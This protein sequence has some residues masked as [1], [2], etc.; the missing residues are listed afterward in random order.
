MKHL[1]AIVALSCFTAGCSRGPALN[2]AGSSFVHPVMMKWVAEY[3]TETGT[4]INYQPIG[5]GGGIGR[6]LAGEVDFACTDGP[7]TD[8][9]L[10]TAKERGGRI[11]HVP[12]VLGA[13]V[14]AYNL[15]GVKKPLR[16]SG[17]VLANIYLGKV[18]KWNDPALR[19][20]NPDVSLP[21]QD[22]TVV[23]RSDGSGTTYIWTEYLSRVSPEWKSRVGFGTGKLKWPCGVGA[24]QNKGVTA[25]VKE[26]AGAIGYIELTYALEND[27]AFGL[28]RN[29][30]GQLI[31]AD[32]GSVNA[33]AAAVVQ[34]GHLP[35]DLRLSLVDL[36]DP[37]AYPVSGLTFAIMNTNLEAERKKAVVN[38]LRWVISEGQRYPEPLHYAR[39]PQQL[40]DLAEE[41]LDEINAR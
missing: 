35:A 1:V 20:L 18:K 2:G 3:K 7:L 14:P 34:A 41:K 39:L 40:I 38:F 37:H 31:K 4:A 28:V 30:A 27:L 8:A 5:S 17:P 13:V 24:P 32:L 21:D 25:R 22:I 9:Q 6:L 33:A 10:E 19:D 12:L 36:P 29:R 23:H 16:F 26:S 11:V 15:P